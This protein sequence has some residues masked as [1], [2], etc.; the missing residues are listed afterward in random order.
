[1]KTLNAHYTAV[2]EQKVENNTFLQKV[3]KKVKINTRKNNNHIE[4]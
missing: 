2:Q 4:C 3:A 1:M